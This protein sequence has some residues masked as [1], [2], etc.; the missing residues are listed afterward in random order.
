MS[1]GTKQR[2]SSGAGK[3]TSTH[4][5]FRKHALQH[6]QERRLDRLDGLRACVGRAGGARRG[7][8]EERREDDEESVQLRVRRWWARRRASRSPPALALH[9]EGPGPGPGGGGVLPEPALLEDLKGQHRVGREG[10]RRGGRKTA[11][12][13]RRRLRRGSARALLASGGPR[14]LGRSLPEERVAQIEQDDVVRPAHEEPRHPLA[15][16]L[17]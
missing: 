3:E 11:R 7:P 17:E 15:R 1:G 8:G 10:L 16:D 13:R 6:S 14:P 9:D 2:R 12:R 4:L 5:V